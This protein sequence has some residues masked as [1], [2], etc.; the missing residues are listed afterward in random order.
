MISKSIS[1]RAYE[2]SV[3][4]GPLDFDTGEEPRMEDCSKGHSAIYNEHIAN[5]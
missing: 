2:I 5:Y 3:S 1:G 4:V